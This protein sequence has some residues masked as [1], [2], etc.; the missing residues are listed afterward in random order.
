MVNKAIKSEHDMNALEADNRKRAAPSSYGGSS[1]RARTGPTPAP[2]V[3]GYGAPQPMW[4]AR[5]PPDPQGQ[6]QCS[7]GQ[8]RGG[9]GNVPRGPCYNCGGQGH[10]SQECPSPK[11]G[12]A[13]NVPNQPTPSQPNRQGSKNGQAPKRGRLNHISTEEASEDEQVLV[14]MVSI[15]SIY[16]RALFDFGA[17]HSFMSIRFAIEHQFSIRKVHTPFHID[18]PG[19]TLVTNEVVNLAHLDVMGL[20]FSI[21]FD[22]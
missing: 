9:G 18:A 4:M 22:Y 7:M 10:Y 21:S 20:T 8:P 13:S 11:K 12:G 19:A 17:S 6:V 15:N 3:P 16:T 5:H 14:G 2:R 1:Q